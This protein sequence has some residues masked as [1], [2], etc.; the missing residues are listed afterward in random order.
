MHPQQ[1]NPYQSNTFNSNIV[2][3][4]ITLSQNETGE[5]NKVNQYGSTYGNITLQNYNT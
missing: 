2:G 3:P 1:P 5:L 4:Q